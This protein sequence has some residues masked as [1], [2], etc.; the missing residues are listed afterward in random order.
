M[1]QKMKKSKG[2]TL[3]EMLVVIAIIAVLVSIV[4]PVVGNSTA[5]ARAAADAANL[6]S[7]AST[8]MIEYLEGVEGEAIEGNNL[9]D[10]LPPKS[11]IA[12]DAD[13]VTLEIWLVNNAVEAYYVSGGG[14][15][16]VAEFADAAEGKDLAA[17]TSAPDADDDTQLYSSED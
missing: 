8:A 13:T 6:R 5:K 4:V 9:P 14:Y 11:T 7:A 15:Y 1:I 16:G 10:I 3:I 17:A 2:F 12:D